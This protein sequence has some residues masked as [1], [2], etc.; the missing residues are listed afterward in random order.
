MA[1][2][3]ERTRQPRTTLHGRAVEDGTFHPSDHSDEKDWLV[4]DI[5]NNNGVSG[6][7]LLEIC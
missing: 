1:E 2:V 5:F 6:Q 7:L 3:C 4:L